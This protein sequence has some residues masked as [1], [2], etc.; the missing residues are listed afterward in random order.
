MRVYRIFP[1]LLHN[2]AHVCLH[3]AKEYKSRR[4]LQVFVPRFRL[5][6]RIL[7][8]FFVWYLQYDGFPARSLF[9]LPF[10]LEPPLNR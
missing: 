7:S 10:R 3:Y 6:E 8:P 4:T 9:H 1:T 5:Q 2:Q